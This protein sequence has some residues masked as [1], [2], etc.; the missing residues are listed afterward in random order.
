MKVVKSKILLH[1]ASHL[2]DVIQGCSPK[3]LACVEQS[4]ARLLHF[5]LFPPWGLSVPHQ[6]PLQAFTAALKLLAHIL[7]PA[8]IPE[9]QGERER[10][11]FCKIY[12][13]P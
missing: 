12:L 2:Q 5:V 6:R 10:G 11:I 7:E 1:P 3:G 8:N 9:R 13:L 4:I